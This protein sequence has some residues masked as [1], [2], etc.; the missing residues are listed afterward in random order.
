[1][2]IDRKVLQFIDEHFY[3]LG[4]FFVTAT[5]LNEIA[6][7]HQCY[8]LSHRTTSIVSSRTMHIIYKN[9]NFFRRN[10][11]VGSDPK[12]NCIRKWLLFA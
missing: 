7:Y 9:S 11:S 8:R 1:M 2:K 12:K 3:D 10:I 4:P 5:E 6:F